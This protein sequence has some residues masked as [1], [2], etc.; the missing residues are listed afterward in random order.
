MKTI[1]FRTD[2]FAAMGYGHLIRCISLAGHIRTRGIV[3]RFILR[4]SE[5][6]AEQLLDQHGFESIYIS[7]EKELAAIVTA[8]GESLAVFDINSSA[9]FGSDADYTKMLEQHRQN[10]IKLVSFEE[11][12]DHPFAS[13]LVIIPYIGA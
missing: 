11:F 5:K 13:D 1:F 2:A 7:E 4:K 8:A 3:P 9:L 12:R 6:Q 10:G